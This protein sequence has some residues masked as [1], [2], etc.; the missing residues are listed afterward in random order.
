[1]ELYGVLTTLA[2]LTTYINSTP[3]SATPAVALADGATIET[4]P[5]VGCAGSFIARVRLLL[6]IYTVRVVTG[7]CMALVLVLVLLVL[8]CS[9]LGVA[10]F[11]TTPIALELACVVVLA[12]PATHPVA[13]AKVCRQPTATTTTS[14]STLQL[15]LTVHPIPTAP[16]ALEFACVVVLAASATHPVAVA[17]V[18]RQRG[19]AV[20][21]C[22]LP[23]Q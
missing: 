9:V 19:V 5:S 8:L 1:M 14:T 11:S 20:T 23:W 13:V 2:T 21:P 12:A 18:S 6:P 10:F 15:R 3:A 4:C 17:E 22:G 7:A 16:I